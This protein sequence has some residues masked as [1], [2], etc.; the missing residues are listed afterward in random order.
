MGFTL[1]DWK[2]VGIFL[3]FSFGIAWLVALWLYLKG[4]LQANTTTLVILAVGYM[5]A[6]AFAHI[7]TRLVTREGWQGL[8]LRP[9]FKQ[10]WKFWLICWIS[11]TLFV[12]AGMAV[13]F[14]LFPKMRTIDRANQV[15]PAGFSMRLAFTITC[16][17][18]AFVVASILGLL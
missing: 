13:Y 17:I 5:G 4:G 3:T 8:F 6:P 12:F 1:V 15:E 14:V 9:K 2:R 7:L 18:F 10:G 11:P 16:L